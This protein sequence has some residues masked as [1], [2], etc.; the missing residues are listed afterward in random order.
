MPQVGSLQELVDLIVDNLDEDRKALKT[1]SL[2]S[3]G[4]LSRCRR[5]LF[6]ELVVNIPYRNRKRR[7]WINGEKVEFNTMTKFNGL[8]EIL[9]SPLCTFHSS[10]TQIT[11]QGSRNPNGRAMTSTQKNWLTHILRPKYLSNWRNVTALKFEDFD[12]SFEFEHRNGTTWESFL[13]D[14]TDPIF[15]EFRQRINRLS[16]LYISTGDAIAMFDVLNIVSRFPGLQEL[17]LGPYNPHEE[18]E[19]EDSDS[20]DISNYFDLEKLL[21]IPG[22]S[23]TNLTVLDITTEVGLWSIFPSTIVWKWAIHHK[24]IVNQLRVQVD[25]MTTADFPSFAEYLYLLGASLKDLDLSIT[26]HGD[27]EDVDSHE[28]RLTRRKS[29][30]LLGTFVE[31]QRCVLGRSIGLETLRLESIFCYDIRNKCPMSLVSPSILFSNLTGQSLAHVEIIIQTD[32]PESEEHIDCDAENKDWSNADRILT[33]FPVLKS[34]LVS[35][36][37]GEEHEAEGIKESDVVDCFKRLL[38]QSLEKGLLK[39]G[40]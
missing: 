6:D 30:D 8:L 34:V 18:P 3:S 12:I 17:H 20:A 24:L 7:Y 13:S 23:S 38:A 15:I 27:F 39:F 26:F 10:I 2:V 16:F 9:N 31:P 32:A 22:P 40:Q 25:M 29:R 11:L 36:Y 14:A 4:W 37:V 5:Y 33:S 1:C 19:I 28:R 21:R 35:V